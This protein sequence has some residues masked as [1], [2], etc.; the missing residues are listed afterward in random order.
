MVAMARE[1]RGRVDIEASGRHGG[2]GAA[3][4]SVYAGAS[5]ERD[6][7]PRMSDRALEN[8][9]RA[10]ENLRLNGSSPGLMER[11]AGVGASI[12]TVMGGIATSIHFSADR[13]GIARALGIG[14]EDAS[15]AFPLLGVAAGLLVGYAFS[16]RSARV[17]DVETGIARIVAERSLP[18]KGELKALG[19]G[20]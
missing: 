16:R 14:I 12:A 13:F 1:A 17:N 3:P 18:E 10:E 6:R 19:A 5:P 11:L 8:S 2:V 7:A 15:A 4:A 9:I 20:R